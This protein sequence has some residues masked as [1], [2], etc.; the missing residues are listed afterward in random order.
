MTENRQAEMRTLRLLRYTG[1]IHRGTGIGGSLDTLQ[2]RLQVPISSRQSKG[3]GHQEAVFSW[4][5]AHLVEAL[6]GKRNEGGIR[7]Q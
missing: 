5:V 2:R 3:T 7:D 4:G 6:R 1:E